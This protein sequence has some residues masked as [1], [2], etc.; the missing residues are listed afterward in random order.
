MSAV[1]M[2]GSVRRIAERLA[3]SRIFTY[4]RLFTGV[5]AKVGLQ[6]LQSRVR[7]V[8]ALELYTTAA[9]LI[10]VSGHN[11]TRFNSPLSS[12]TW[13]SRYQKGKTNLD[14]L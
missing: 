6:V 11:N 5:R 10:F 1:L 9:Q 12:T 4:V 14:L 3:A 8:A 7:L 13:V 2:L